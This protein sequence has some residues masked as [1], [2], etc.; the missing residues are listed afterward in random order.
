MKRIAGSEESKIFPSYGRGKTSWKRVFKMPL[1][2]GED[3]KGDSEERASGEAWQHKQ[4]NGTKKVCLYK[5]RASCSGHFW[6]D[7]QV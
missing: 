5:A 1:E 2:N 6:S 3:L 4:S 7:Y